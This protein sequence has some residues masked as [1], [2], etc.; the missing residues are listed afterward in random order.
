MGAM[1]GLGRLFNVVPIA[2][3]RGLLISA[4]SG[5]T[6]VTTGSDTFTLTSATSFAGSYTTPGTLTCN[7]YKNAATNG[8]AAWVKDNTLIS[9]N[10]I[11]TTVSTAFH[12]TGSFIHG[13][14]SNTGKM[15]V[16]LSAGGSGLVMAVLHDLTVQRTPPNLVI[17]S[18]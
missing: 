12:I 16:K 11:V 2:A 1:E 13:S 5:I 6:F 3:G 8:S 7:V 9:T 18:A 4:N 17:A 14:A 10:T 15:Y